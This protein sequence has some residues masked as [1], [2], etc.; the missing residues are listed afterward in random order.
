MLFASKI[1]STSLIIFFIFL[2]FPRSS[3]RPLCF[4]GSIL[5]ILD[6][7]RIASRPE[8]K[9]SKVVNNDILVNVQNLG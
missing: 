9:H 7:G 2:I 5:F 6:E 3:I 1:G 4:L 8:I